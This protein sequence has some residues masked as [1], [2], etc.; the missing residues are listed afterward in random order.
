[1]MRHKCR[2]MKK[3]WSMWSMIYGVQA[4][5][6]K[7]TW[8]KQARVVGGRGVVVKKS[9][10]G[11][12]QFQV[13][14]QRDKKE[15]CRFRLTHRASRCRSRFMYIQT[16]ERGYDLVHEWQRGTYSSPT[17]SCDA[18][19]SA[20]CQHHFPILRMWVE[21]LQRKAGN[22]SSAAVHSCMLR[23]AL[24]V[25]IATAKTAY[26]CGSIRLRRPYHRRIDDDGVPIGFRA[27]PSEAPR[28]HKGVIKVAGLGE[29]SRILQEEAEDCPLQGFL[30]AP[31][32]P[33]MLIVY[34]KPVYAFF[35]YSRIWRKESHDLNPSP[36]IQDELADRGSIPRF[37][38]VPSV[39]IARQ[40]RNLE[41][42]TSQR[43]AA[44]ARNDQLMARIQELEAQMQSAWALGLSNEPPPGYSTG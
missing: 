29:D 6:S 22:S 34:I 36:M 37:R 12:V 14:I 7:T 23:N 18:E 15:L 5:R 44:R 1:M 33:A 24:G 42:A 35:N 13:E 16:S 20:P 43:D 25:L 9:Q 30:M 21:L 32:W 3:N 11:I 39:F 31:Q 8:G 2:E 19:F 26:T 41:Q 4:I 28:I 17:K 38:D 40:R 10:F 27:R